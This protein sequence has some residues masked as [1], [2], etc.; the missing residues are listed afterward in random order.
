MQESQNTQETAA[1]TAQGK[2][3]KKLKRNG[4]K[5]SF[6]KKGEEVDE[7]QKPPMSLD[8]T[9]KFYKEKLPF[10]KLQDEY[11]ELMDRF[12][13]RKVRHLERQ[14]R[15]I[16]AI[17]FL[18]QWKAQQDN[19]KRQHDAEEEMK[20]KWEAMTPE[21]KEE[22]KTQAKANLR[23]MELQAKGKV[24]YDGNNAADIMSF[25]TG[26]LHQL[27][28]V[29]TPDQKFSFQIPNP[30]GGHTDISIVPGQTLSR[31]PESGEFIVSIE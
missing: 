25:V 21:E 29:D 6:K 31:I 17:G 27:M 11:E 22:Y 10:L 9:M 7:Q 1:E 13:D 8:E 12:H 5:D 19:A 18:G 20:A 14:V 15:E 30:Q 26:E 4:V 2:G 24:L 28:E 23:L 16:E 3:P